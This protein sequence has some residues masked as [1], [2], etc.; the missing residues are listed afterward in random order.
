MSK[1][2]GAPEPQDEAPKK[3]PT[4]IA[5]LFFLVPLLLLI[6]FNLLAKKD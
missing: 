5:I 3:S 2:E 1:T 6:L 4:G